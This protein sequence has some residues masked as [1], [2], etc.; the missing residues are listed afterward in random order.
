MSESFRDFRAGRWVACGVLG[1]G[2]F[3]TVFKAS[4]INCPTNMVALKRLALDEGDGIPAPVLR[5]VGGLTIYFF[6]N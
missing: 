3:A 5:E 2:G 4:D 1:S 6:S